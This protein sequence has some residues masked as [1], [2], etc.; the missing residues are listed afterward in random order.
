MRLRQRERG[1][2]RRDTSAVSWAPRL[3]H[4]AFHGG[5][6]FSRSS[7]LPPVCQRETG[8]D[9]VVVTSHIGAQV[10]TPAPTMPSPRDVTFVSLPVTGSKRVTVVIEIV[11]VNTQ[12]TPPQ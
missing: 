10:E 9:S 6:A 2:K 12:K 5:T 11:E 1:S 7:G 4:G 8:P 3:E